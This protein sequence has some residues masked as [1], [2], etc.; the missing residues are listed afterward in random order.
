MDDDKG[1]GGFEQTILY[2]LDQIFSVGE[3][4]VESSVLVVPM[5]EGE[6]VIGLP[7]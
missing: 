3:Q 6:N 4:G 2:R 7:F 5:T 1:V